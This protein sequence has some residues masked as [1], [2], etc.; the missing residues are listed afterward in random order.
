MLLFNKKYSILLYFNIK[1]EKENRVKL[2][3]PNGDQED[4]ASLSPDKVNNWRGIHEQNQLQE[5]SR[6]HSRNFSKEVKEEN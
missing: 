4:P 5:S 1:Q 6:V 3:G 2:R